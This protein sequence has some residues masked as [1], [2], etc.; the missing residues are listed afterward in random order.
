MKDTIE[1]ISLDK[2]SDK[3]EIK[4][5]NEYIYEKIIRFTYKYM[6]YYQYLNLLENFDLKPH[7]DILLDLHTREKNICKYIELNKKIDNE[8][9]PFSDDKLFTR[10]LSYDSL[11]KYRKG[12][13]DSELYAKLVNALL[14]KGWYYEP[15]DSN[16]TGDLYIV[17]KEIDKKVYYYISESFYNH[18]PDKYINYYNT[19]VDWD[20]FSDNEEV[21]FNHKNSDIIEAIIEERLGI[22]KNYFRKPWNGGVREKGDLVDYHNELEIK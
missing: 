11:K 4:N 21:D 2:L 20:V 5:S 22:E 15:V 7:D 9:D 19:Y 13:Y 1:E 12:D 14:P 18:D 3:S 6:N 16:Y 10:M 17:E 8:Y